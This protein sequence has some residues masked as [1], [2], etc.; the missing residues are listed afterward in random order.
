M[1]RSPH[2]HRDWAAYI[3]LNVALACL[4]ATSIW[5]YTSF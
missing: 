3:S 4:I 5:Y 2:D 1:N